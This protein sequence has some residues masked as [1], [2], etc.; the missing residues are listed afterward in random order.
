MKEFTITK[1]VSK[2]GKNSIIVIPRVLEGEIN[3][4][5]LVELKIRLIKKGGE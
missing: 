4:R 1:R 2:Q 5:D 3:P